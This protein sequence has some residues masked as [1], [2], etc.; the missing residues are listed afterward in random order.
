MIA[1]DQ[2]RKRVASGVRACCE[3][4][5]MGAKHQVAWAKRVPTQVFKQPVA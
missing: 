5:G 1:F 3:T 2:S 4:V